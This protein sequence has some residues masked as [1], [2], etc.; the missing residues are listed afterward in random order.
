[1]DDDDYAFDTIDVIDHTL[2]KE[3][4]AF[5]TLLHTT[6]KKKV[7]AT[8]GTYQY[9]LDALYIKLTPTIVGIQRIPPPEV[10]RS[11][12]KK[13]CWSNFIEI[14]DFIH[15]DPEHVL[16]FFLA[17]LATDGNLDGT[18]RLLFHSRFSA[19]QIESVLRKYIL[20]YVMCE[21]CKTLDT[22]VDKDP[23][24]RLYFMLCK[25]CNSNRSVQPIKSG[26]RS[27][28]KADRKAA[29]EAGK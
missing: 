18:M 14:C 17:E 3:L 25:Q 20:E 29:K 9:Y 19:N 24:T 16:A 22:V 15:R 7:S 8:P 23:V 13:S 11:G 28:T 12:P 21:S 1:M 2:E 10:T 26:F 4:E 5:E 27:T 6:R